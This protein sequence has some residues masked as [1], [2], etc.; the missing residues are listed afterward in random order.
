MSNA[1]LKYVIIVAVV[2]GLAG[3][4]CAYADVGAKIG[5]IVDKQV[6]KKVVLGVEILRADTGEAVYSHNAH[7]ALTP[8]SNMKL[9]TSS[10]AVNLLGADY[11]FTT[12]VG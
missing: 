7:A 6:K 9:I 8:A 3:G 4:T 2:C 5:S 10:A 11:Q 12:K 1:I